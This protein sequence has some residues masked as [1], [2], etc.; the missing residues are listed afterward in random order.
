MVPL[1]RCSEIARPAD[2][3]REQQVITR[4]H[5]QE[6][7]CQAYVL[8]LA[9][10]AGVNL[11]LDRIYDYGVDGTFRPVKILGSR[12]VESGFNLDFQLK[13]TVNWAFN[14]NQTHVV[15]DLEAKTYN[16]LACREVEGDGCVLI[17]LCLSMPI[18][19][20]S[21]I[22]F[23]EASALRSSRRYQIQLRTLHL[24]SGRHSRSRDALCSV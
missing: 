4:Q 17:L 21:G 6:T 14:V 24:G 12:R 1:R 7:L 10:K 18:N 8:A 13:S 16:D 19:V 2:S 20:G 15:Y 5:T 9:G 11:S 3:Y 23:A 22:R